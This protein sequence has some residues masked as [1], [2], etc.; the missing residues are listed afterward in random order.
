MFEWAAQLSDDDWANA[1]AGGGENVP[2]MPPADVQ[3]MFVG[4][5]GR[6][7]F[8]EASIFWGRLKEVM[9]REGRPMTPSSKVLDIGVGWGR[10]YRWGLRDLPAENITGI[11]VDPKTISM[12]DDMMPYGDFRHVPP[13]ADY[14]VGYDA[15]VAY[16]VFS[17][18]SANVAKS[19][20]ADTFKA[21]NPGGFVAVT[22]LIPE[23][24]GVWASQTS[25][26]PFKTCLANANFDEAG[27]WERAKK[28]EHLYVPTG[29]G[30]ESRPS[31]AYGEAVAPEG[32]WAG[33]EDWKL[34]EYS[35][36]PHLPQA[37][38]ILQKV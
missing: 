38:V 19:I 22:T 11:D 37:M 20:L 32:W 12:C 26:E 6:D 7:S 35:R 18:V 3:A 31:D 33:L 25:T 9:A 17:H 30:D 5:S 24:I 8:N 34:I 28:G 16:S 13:G 2:A 10:I 27:W 23:H 1:L 14:P 15:A 36:P 29:G 21:L 4:S